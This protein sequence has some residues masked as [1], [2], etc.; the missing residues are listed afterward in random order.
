M[1]ATIRAIRPDEVA[2]V[3]A[4][5]RDAAARFR[6]VGLDAIADGDVSSE[7]FIRAVMA[8]GAALVA[9]FDG[10]LVGFALAGVLDDALHLYELSVA[11]AHHGRGV[12]G[13]LLAALDREAA[14]RH[15]PAVTLSTFS[16]VPFNAPFYAR[17]GFTPVEREDWGPAFHLLHGAELAAGIPVERRVFMRKE[18]A[19]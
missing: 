6:E 17:R 3:P 2:L 16:D 11:T 15:L 18:I 9:E 14:R 19:R 1:T 12:G 7:A 5:E 13:R 10:M 4:I 8:K